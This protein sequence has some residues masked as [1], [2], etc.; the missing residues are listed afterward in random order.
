MLYNH[1]TYSLSS[2]DLKM[3]ESIPQGGNWKNIPLHIPSKRLERIRTTGGRT[4]LYGRLKWDKPSY[5][6]STYFNR[7]GN[8][9]Y[10]HP[11]EN[12]VLSAREAARIQ[13]FPDNYIFCG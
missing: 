6:I 10:I 4:T 11:V 9:S 7:P 5:T 12:R 8:G 3:V 2:L 1:V 13:S